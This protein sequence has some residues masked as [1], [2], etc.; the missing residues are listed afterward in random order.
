MAIEGIVAWN[1]REATLS[2]A[3]AKKEYGLSHE[4]IIN[5]IRRGEL[6]FREGNMHGNLWLRLFRKEVENL[7]VKL[8]GIEY[9]KSRKNQY[10]L[11]KIEKELRRLKKQI[12]ELEARKAELLNLQ[13]DTH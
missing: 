6:Q 9:L 12:K 8:Y 4:E 10:E 11:V 13:H 5:A 3:S 1:D 7:V 2:D